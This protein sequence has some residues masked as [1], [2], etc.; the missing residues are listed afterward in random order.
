MRIGFPCQ[1]KPDKKLIPLLAAK[2]PAGNLAERDSFFEYI[3][4]DDYVARG[5]SDAIMY[6]IIEGD[7]MEDVGLFSGD[8]LV[9][10]RLK[11]PDCYDEILVQ[12]NGE[13]TVKQWKD[14][15]DADNRRHLSLVPKNNK[16]QTRKLTVADK[17][18]ILGVVEYSVSRR[19]NRKRK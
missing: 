12:I 13:I 14:I 2:V 10:D 19:K 11:Q 4:L 15:Y 16:Y 8:L 18:E 3:S 9:I 7:S 1:H 6:I 5:S 17:V